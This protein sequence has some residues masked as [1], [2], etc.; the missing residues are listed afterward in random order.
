MSY[1]LLA[2]AIALNVAGQLLLKRAAMAGAGAG[3]SPL[4]AFMSPYLCAGVASLGA[5]MLLWV[6]VLRK[7]P[8]TLAHPITGLVFVVV[9][10]ASHFLWGEELPATR[11]VGILIIIFGVILVA[12]GA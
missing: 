4:K 9:P 5:S 2:V 3:V 1:V 7:V 10:V 8:L 12:R 11:I 6:Q